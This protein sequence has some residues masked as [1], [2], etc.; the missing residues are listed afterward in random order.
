MISPY[1]SELTGFVNMKN[2]ITIQRADAP[3]VV[4][5]IK[6]VDDFGVTILRAYSEKDEDGRLE[7]FIA[8]EDIRGV[9]Q[10]VSGQE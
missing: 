1:K 5:Q 2:M 10:M 6:N 8:F 7:L 3:D 9:G 4:G